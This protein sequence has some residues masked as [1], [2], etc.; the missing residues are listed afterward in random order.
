MPL[1]PFFLRGTILFLTQVHSSSLHGNTPLLNTG[2]LTLHGNTLLLDTGTLLYTGTLLV[3]TQEQSSSH[4]WG[5]LYTGLRNT[6]LLCIHR[7]AAHLDTSTLSFTQVH[8]SIHRNSALFH[9]WM[10]LTL[11][12]ERSSSQFIYWVTSGLFSKSNLTEVEYKEYNTKHVHFT[13]IKHVIVNIIW[14][15]VPLVWLS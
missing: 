9:T 4:R 15:L 3:S 2:T 12:Q 10:L 11:T 1:Q 8:S 14:K 13:I 5:I 7:N 6:P